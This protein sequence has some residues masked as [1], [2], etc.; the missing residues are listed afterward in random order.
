MLIYIHRK[1]ISLLYEFK[2]VKLLYKMVGKIA[3]RILY[4]RYCYLLFIKIV[5]LPVCLEIFC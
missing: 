1:I 2:N 5:K 3:P 4:C